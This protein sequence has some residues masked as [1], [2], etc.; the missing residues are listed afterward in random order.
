MDHDAQIDLKQ[1]TASYFWSRIKR[2][3]SRLADT[4]ILLGTKNPDARVALA[5][6]DRVDPK[7][8][9]SR[10]TLSHPIKLDLS[11][12]KAVEQTRQRILDLL[13][14]QI[15]PIEE[16]EAVMKIVNDAGDR[17]VMAD[18]EDLM[19]AVTEL[20]E[21]RLGRASTGPEPVPE[22]GVLGVSE[23]SGQPVRVPKWGVAKAHDK[24]V[25]P[26]G[27]STAEKLDDS[28]EE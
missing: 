2:A 17:S 10:Q 20:R 9:Y 15:L 7:P 11:D 18:I 1:E 5:I 19:K 8:K 24:K 21:D 26:I 22:D 6:F 23:I 12:P 28:P 16:A 14:G 3:Q 27:G 25:V 4:L 13:G